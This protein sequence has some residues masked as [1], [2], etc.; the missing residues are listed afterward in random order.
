MRDVK[1]TSSSA[2]EF[3]N[4]IN[5]KKQTIS[6]DAEGKLVMPADMQKR[7]NG[8]VDWEKR[9]RELKQ[10]LDRYRSRTGSYDVLV[11]GSGGKDPVYASHILKQVTWHETS[12][13]DMVSTF[14]L[15]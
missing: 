5:V 15:T 13:G 4:N 9:E 8:E 10:L 12:Y 7:K 1:P 6:F 14:I 3:Q 11:P 2:I